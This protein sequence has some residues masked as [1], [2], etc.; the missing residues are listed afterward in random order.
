MVVD[1]VEERGFADVD[2]KWGDPRKCYFPLI[3]GMKP[4]SLPWMIV[5]YSVLWAGAFGIMLGFYFK[6]A[7]AFFIIPYW[8]LFVLDK[9]YWNN[10]TYLF[11]IVSLLFSLSDAN[12]YLYVFYTFFHKQKHYTWSPDIIPHMNLYII[13]YIIFSSLDAILS[14]S[15]TEIVPAWNYFALKFQFFILYFLAGLKKGCRE[16]LEGYAMTNLSNHWVFEPF[17]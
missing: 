17:K 8:Y 3:H 16:W 4:L 11:G 7:C 2:I 6:L 5:L 9:S 12:K 10:H 13:P 15:K 14:K 1:V